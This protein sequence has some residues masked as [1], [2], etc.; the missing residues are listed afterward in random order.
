MENLLLIA[1]S[2][3][4]SSCSLII[5]KR[6]SVKTWMMERKIEPWT[7]E[8]VK[9]P[10]CGKGMIAGITKATNKKIWYCPEW[11]KCKTYLE[12]HTGERLPAAEIE[13][14]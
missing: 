8:K 9:C 5:W 4:M 7:A 13:G 3:I 12:H 10:S 14:A 1:I 11:Q 6:K 2:L